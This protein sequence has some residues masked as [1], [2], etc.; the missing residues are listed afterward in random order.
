MLSNE[1]FM[2]LLLLGTKVP[3]NESF[4]YAPFVP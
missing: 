3:G 2:L 4:T 1:S